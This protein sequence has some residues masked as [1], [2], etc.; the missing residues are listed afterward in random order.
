M[1]PIEHE[2]NID[3]IEESMIYVL[4]FSE[5]YASST[6]CLD[7]LTKILDCK[8]RYG[9]VVIPVFYKVDPSIVRNQR[10]TYAEVFVKHEHRFEDKIDKVHAWKAAQ[11]K[12]CVSNSIKFIFVCVE[13]F[14]CSFCVVLASHLKN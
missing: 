5:N 2:S 7:E 12:A 9:R 13:T 6:W 4:V 10:E 1:N 3:S 14:M 11:T 8:K